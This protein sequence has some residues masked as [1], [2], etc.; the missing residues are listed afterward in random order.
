MPPCR[1]A[2]RY[3]T[4]ARLC[5]FEGGAPTGSCRRAPLKPPTADATGCPRPDAFQPLLMSFYHLRWLLSL[6]IDA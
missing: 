4:A 3:G 2:E 1:D 5:S 6:I